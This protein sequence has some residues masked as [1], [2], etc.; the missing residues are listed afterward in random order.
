V[1]RYAMIALLLLP[2]PFA[3]L[4]MLSLAFGGSHSPPDGN[5]FAYSGDLPQDARAATN[6]WTLNGDR[7]WPASLS[8]EVSKTTASTVASCA[9]APAAIEG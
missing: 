2:L 5:A 6:S 7:L 9:G 1:R 3:A 4:P 8:P